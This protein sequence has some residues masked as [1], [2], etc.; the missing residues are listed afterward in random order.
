MGPRE[1]HVGKSTSKDANMPMTKGKVPSQGCF[2]VGHGFPRGTEQPLR[3]AVWPPQVPAR[4]PA[5]QQACPAHTKLQPT[6]LTC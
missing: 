5:T 3:I 1:V 2:M 6:L 4:Q